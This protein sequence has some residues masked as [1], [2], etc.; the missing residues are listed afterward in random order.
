MEKHTSMRIIAGAIIA[1]AAL[2][3]IAHAQTGSGTPVFSS[4]P[5]RGYVVGVAESAFGNATSQSYGGEV[6]FRI[7]DGVEVYAEGGRVRNAATDT[8]GVSA[9][10]I[11]GFLSQTQGAAAFTAKTPVTFGTAGVRYLFPTEGHAKPYV[12][13]GGGFAQVKQDVQFT[14]NGNDVTGNMDQ[15]GVTLGTDLSGTENKAMLVLGVGVVWTAWK[16]FVIDARYRYGR[17]FTS[18]AFNVSRAGLGLGIRF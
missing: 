1:T 7:A 13:A 8:L 11:A 12:M 5:D 10:K 15:L 17:I 4:N 18:T 14:V 2:S 6:G 16:P 9:Q 3:G